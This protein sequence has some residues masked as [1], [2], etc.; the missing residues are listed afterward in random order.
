MTVMLSPPYLPLVNVIGERAEILNQHPLVEAHKNVDVLIAAQI[1]LQPLGLGRD[2]YHILR[3]AERAEVRR[4]RG[5]RP[6]LG[7]DGFSKIRF[8]GEKMPRVL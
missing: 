2:P 7:R 4:R 8:G 3:A 5:Y 6:R 1:D